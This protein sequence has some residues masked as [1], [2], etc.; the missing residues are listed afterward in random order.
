M[1]ALNCRDI[2][3]IIEEININY[4]GCVNIAQLAYKYLKETK[5]SLLFFTS[6]S[7]TRG[8]AMYSIY[9]STKAA[10]VNLTQA[11]A[12]EWDKDGIRL[13]VICPERTATPMRF[14]NFGKEPEESL[15]KPEIVANASLNTLLSNYTGQVIDVKRI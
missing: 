10:V 11:L 14:E 12:E 2:K 1:G 8:R 6:S 13:N 5:G 9:S 4:I 3:D 15:L 7:Y